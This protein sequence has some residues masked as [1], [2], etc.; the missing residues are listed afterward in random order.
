MFKTYA[1]LTGQDIDQEILRTY[2][3]AQGDGNGHRRPWLEP[4]Q[5]PHCRA[6]NGP[7]SNFCS[8][9]GRTLTEEATESMDEC[10]TIAKG[11]PEYSLLLKQLRADPVRAG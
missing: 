6:V 3:I 4:W 8:L 7:S 5:C 9:C 10:I 11:P 2:G 1:H